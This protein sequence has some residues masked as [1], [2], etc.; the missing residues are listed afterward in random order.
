MDAPYARFAFL[1]AYNLVL[2]AAAIVVGLATG[3]HWLVVVTCGVELLW[4][5]FAPDSK[6]LRRVWFDPTFAE[7][8]RLDRLEARTAKLRHLSPDDALRAGRLVEQKVLIE[9]LARD[10]PSLAVDLLQTELVKLDELLDDFVDLGAA[11]GRAERHTAT[12]DFAEMRRSW[13]VHETQ[14]R[15]HRPGDA[16]REVAE[17]NLDVLRRRRARYDDL[18]RQLQVLRGQMELIEQTFRLLADEI[19]TMGSPRELGGRIEE[20]RVAVD[21]VRETAC[22]VAFEDRMEGEVVGHE[23]HR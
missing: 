7:S 4:M 3:H 15:Q 6:L 1:N 13:H 14:A 11:A 16:R 2:L 19:L 17:K 10:N 5:I 21:A 12:F 23:E 20:L 22:E 18:V 9:R 8:A